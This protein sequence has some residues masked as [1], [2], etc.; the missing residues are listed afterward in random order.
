ME[1]MRA[2]LDMAKEFNFEYVNFYV[3]MAWPGSKLYEDAVRSGVRLPDTW[4]GYAQLSEE[5][6]PL[7]TK[8]VSAQ[9]VLR[10]RD[11][12]FV[13]Y[14]SN[15]KYYEMMENKFGPEV[16]AH[17]KEMLQNKINRRFA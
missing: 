2:T 6:L 16:A 3:A 4:A 10:F 13:E 17:I 7:P 1:T 11:N 8:Y 15:P 14:F 9:E 5:T 12:A